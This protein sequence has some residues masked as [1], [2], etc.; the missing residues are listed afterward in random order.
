MRNSKISREIWGNVCNLGEMSAQSFQAAPVPFDSSMPRVEPATIEDLP[1]L[2][3]L[4]MELF[5][6]SGDFKPDRATQERGL[7]LILQQPNRGRIFVLRTDHRIIGM[8]NLLI[9]LSTACGG[10]VL[11]M[12]DVVIHHDHRGLGYGSMVVDYVV[13][14]AKQK[15]FKRITLLTDRISDR[16]QNFFHKHGFEFSTMIPMRLVL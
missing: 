1:E 7:E 10:F 5:A 9:T 16:S 6:H 14:F 8:V 15:D 3:A 2:T 13:Q 4:V 11:I 12:E